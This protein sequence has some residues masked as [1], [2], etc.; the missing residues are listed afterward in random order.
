MEATKS[1]KVGKLGFP[2]SWGRLDSK[3]AE[4]GVGGLCEGAKHLIF[5]DV[6]WNVGT[7][8]I[9]KLINFCFLS[10]DRL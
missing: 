4:L 2:Q 9:R 3:P 7:S 5:T 6:P 1:S 10:C 8:K